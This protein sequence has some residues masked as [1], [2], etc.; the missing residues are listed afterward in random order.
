[1][2]E[3][4]IETAVAGEVTETVVEFEPITSQEDLDRLVGSRLDRERKKFADY[5]SLKAQATELEAIKEA[6]KTAEQK[7]ADR[8]AELERAN[9]ELTGEKMR[10]DVAAA[11]GVPASLLTG[12]TQEELEAAAD[13]LIAFRGEQKQAPSSPALGRVNGQTAKLSSAEQFA[14]WAESNQNT[15]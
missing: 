8:V 11:K 9:A 14:Q 1:M 10:S 3:N 15:L 6:N 7:T 2:S 12:S 4:T 5:D 13:A